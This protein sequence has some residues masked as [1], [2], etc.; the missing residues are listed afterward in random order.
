LSPYFIFPGNG[1]DLTRVLK[2]N[3]KFTAVGNKKVSTL[4]I[5]V[6]MLVTCAGRP[7]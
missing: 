3:Q 6:A 1:Y 5:T 7:P 2:G 4:D